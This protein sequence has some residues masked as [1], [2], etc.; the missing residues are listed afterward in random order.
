M[1]SLRVTENTQ[2]VSQ[3]LKQALRLAGG[4]RFVRYLGPKP[5][6]CGGVNCGETDSPANLRVKLLALRVNL[7]IV[8]QIQRVPA[9]VRVC[10]E[11]RHVEPHGTSKNTQ[12][13]PQVFGQPERL[14]PGTATTCASPCKDLVSPSR[15]DDV[16]SLLRAACWEIV[17]T[18]RMRALESNKSMKSAYSSSLSAKK[19]CSR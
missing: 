19:T 5:E 3:A 13:L 6:L 16:A 10:V 18:R 14:L 9:R 15:N 11:T 1:C 4:S 17:T 2:R 12:V 7:D 8:G